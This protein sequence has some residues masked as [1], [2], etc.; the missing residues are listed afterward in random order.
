MRH[1]WSILVYIPGSGDER[2]YLEEDSV[3]DRRSLVV[4]DSLRSLLWPNRDTDRTS[5]VREEN[6][7]FE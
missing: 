5:W 7:D 4:R 3:D 1:Q 2:T 6:I